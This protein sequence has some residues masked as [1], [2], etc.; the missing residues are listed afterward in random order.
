[1]GE[2]NSFNWFL[3]SQREQTTRSYLEDD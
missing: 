1:M 3:K 2:Y